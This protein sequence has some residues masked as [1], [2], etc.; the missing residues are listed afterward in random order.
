MPS[1]SG[2]RPYCYS[3]LFAMLSILPWGDDKTYSTSCSWWILRVSKVWPLLED[4]ANAISKHVCGTSIFNKNIWS[5][6]LNVSCSIIQTPLYGLFHEIPL[7]SPKWF[8][9]FYP[10]MD[11]IRCLSLGRIYPWTMCLNTHFRGISFPRTSKTRY[12]W[13]DIM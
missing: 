3:F 10:V 7:P 11:I 8:S 6:M 4:L 13:Q 12:P 1:T 9:T 5:T 2:Q